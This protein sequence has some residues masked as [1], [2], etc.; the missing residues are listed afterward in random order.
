[1]TENTVV[2]EGY[3]A[4]HYGKEGPQLNYYGTGTAIC[5]MTLSFSNGKDP[6]GN[7]KRGYVECKAFKDI[8]E[9]MYGAEEN[10]DHPPIE[11]G[12]KVII[13]GKFTIDDYN[14]DKPKAVIVVNDYSVKEEEE[15]S[16][17]GTR[18]SSQRRGKLPNGN[19]SSSRNSAPVK[20]V[21]KKVTSARKGNVEEDDEEPEEEERP[22]KKPVKGV[23]FKKRMK[24][25]QEEEEYE[26]DEH[27][28]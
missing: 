7:W 19:G 25:K 24:K 15:D 14:R 17:A 1:M 8:A 6:E 20:K 22:A 2:L 11:Y 12:D 3:C 5:G 23:D 4:K 9:W 27:P 21:V 10:K 16:D 26:L 18:A 13:Y 28:F